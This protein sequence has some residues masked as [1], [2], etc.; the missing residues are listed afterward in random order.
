[1][2]DQRRSCLLLVAS[3]ALVCC[4]GDKPNP[5]A[6]A[7]IGKTFLLDTPAISTSSWTKPSGAL[8][9]NY[10]V[11][12]FFFG[13][14]AGSGDDL[15]ITLAGAQEGNQ[16]T[17]APTTQA[18]ASG[19][20]YPNSTITAAQFPIRVVN[21]D[22]TDPRQMVTTIHDVT[23]RDTLPG[24]DSTATSQFDG[25]FN[26]A[27]LAPFLDP[28]STKDALCQIAAASGSPCETCP[29]DGEPYC[30]SFEAVQVSAKETSA[31]IK[32]IASSDIPVPCPSPP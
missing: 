11:P 4:G 1:M 30:M 12:Q 31:S 27:E 5:K 29:F 23:F 26:F 16:D 28:N 24:L 10:G 14:E 18:V 2:I 3:W 19:A 20:T 15:T 21:K 6:Q 32:N 9:G 8:I 13:V 22:P 17:C 25:I 7:W